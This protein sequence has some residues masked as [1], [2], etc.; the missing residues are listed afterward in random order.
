MALMNPDG[1]KM[2]AEEIAPCEFCGRRFGAEAMARH[3]KVCLKNP[4]RKKKDE[5]KDEKK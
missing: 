3:T 4:D 2:Q 1:S 5:K